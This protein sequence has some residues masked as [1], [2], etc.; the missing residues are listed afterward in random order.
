VNIPLVDL[1]R[2]HEPIREELEE[3]FRGIV[4]RSSFI[5]GEWLER[6][7]N[8]FAKY[9]SIPF[10]V[11]VSSGTAALE[12]PLRACG[13]GSGDEVLVPAFTF[14]A[15]G[16]SVNAVGAK[17][18]FVDVDSRSYTLDLKSAEER[19][20]PQ[21]KAIIPVHLYGHP[22]DM[23]AVSDF[24]GRH[25][26]ILIE[27]AAQAQGARWSGKP[28]GAWGRATGFSFYPA[29]NLGAMGDA[30][31]VITADAGLAYQIR[32]L[33]NHG[34][35][36]DKYCHE[37]LGHNERLDALQAAV[38]DIKLKHLEEWNDSRR[39]AAARYS[40]ALKGLDLILPEE[41]PGARHVYHL[42]VVR[43]PRR[44][45]LREF[46]SKKNIGT[47]YHYPMGYPEGD[48]PIAEQLAREVLSLPLFP[49]ITPAEVDFVAE[50]LHE[51]FSSP[52]GR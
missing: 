48:F 25:H 42:Y 52:S 27:D 51:F 41:R 40:A 21:T 30:G 9:C 20:T 23:D 46:L 47:G 26:L 44:D 10:A 35:L 43:T 8:D 11:G 36:R 39:T 17:P 4:Q 16:A 3:A 13:I 6:F 5:G 22:A 50:C 29:K 33:R 1:F 31:A 49:G 24:A 18:V 12:L 38:L 14:I 32:L 7:E 15:T 19:I 34:S 45:E 2:Q 37:I 28:V